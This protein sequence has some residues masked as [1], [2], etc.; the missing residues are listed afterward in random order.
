VNAPLAA[1][2]RVAARITAAATTAFLVIAP[3]TSSSG[4][5]VGL[6]VVAALALGH[7]AFHHG[8]HRLAGPL[9][10]HLAVLYALWAL[11]ATASLLWSVD[12]GYTLAELRREVLYGGLAFAVFFYAATGAGRLRL[13]AGAL[14]AGTAAL[15]LFEIVRA[16]AA[17]GLAP[18]HGG[19]GRFSTHLA[20]VAPFLLLLVMGPP[21]GF[22]RPRALAA[23]AFACFGI[24]ALDTHNR[25][26]WAA[27]LAA[28]VTVA[29]GILPV[30][31]ADARRRFAL[32]TILAA[33]GLAGLF[34]LSLAQKLD[35]SYPGASSAAETFAL[36]HRHQLWSIATEVI[37]ERPVA[38]HGFGRE[39]LERRYRERMAGTGYEF[40]THGHN[41]FLNTAVSLGALGVALLT[42]LLAALA[43]EHG[44][45]LARPGTRVLGAIGL[46]LLAAFLVKNLT[47]DFF[48]RH[49]ALVFWALNGMLVGLGRRPSGGGG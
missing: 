23:V 39:V 13:W 5:R 2:E 49:N 28:L 38:G 4:W 12:P 40:A 3:V 25:I 32:G 21:E 19:P 33:A 14:I 27:F 41:L 29:I 8:R 9:P 15:A 11:L 7:I 6:L 37:E 31:S 26:V 36:D 30:V 46:A 43:L 34:A 44:R 17:P 22:G 20:L 24:A 42:A 18:W 48:N 16:H 10:R 45:N 1:D 47:D 35:V